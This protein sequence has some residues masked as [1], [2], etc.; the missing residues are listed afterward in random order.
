MTAFDDALAFTLP[1]ECGRD[2]KN[3]R[4]NVD[5]HKDH[6]GRTSRGITQRTYDGACIAYGWSKGDV[7][8]ATDEQV[9]TIYLKRFWQRAFCDH[10]PAPLGLAVFDTAVLHGDGFA[11]RRLQA[12]LRVPVDGQFGP[13]TWRA[14][15]RTSPKLL[16]EDFLQLRDDRYEE[17]IAGDPGQARFYKGWEGRCDAL[18]D[19]CGVPRTKD[20]VHP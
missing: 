18:C 16:T 15:V 4:G 8:E 6:G 1:W 2:P 19:A 10:L 5:D 14:I 13:I 17:L 20:P 12:A 9:S 7:W 11:K 3:P